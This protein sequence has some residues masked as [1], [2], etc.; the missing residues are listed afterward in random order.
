MQVET[1]EN[2]KMSK[3]EIIQLASEANERNED[4]CSPVRFWVQDGRYFVCNDITDGD[5][6][7]E[8]TEKAFVK[9]I[10]IVLGE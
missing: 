4:T 1:K 9:K 7:D 3:E 6:I 8:L 10:K 5:D 2:M